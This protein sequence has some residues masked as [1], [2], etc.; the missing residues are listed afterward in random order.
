MDNIRKMLSIMLGKIPPK[1]IL[2][3]KLTYDD[4]SEES[5]VRLSTYYAN[6]YSNTELHNLYSCLRDEYERQTNWLEGKAYRQISHKMNVFHVV[7]VFAMHVLIEYD[8]I[9]VCRYENLLRWRMTSHELDEDIF[10]T[11]FLAYNDLHHFRKRE[12]FYWR[13]VIGHNNAYLNRIL[14]Q[15]MAEN[16]FH[17]KG[18]APQFP[19]SWINLMND[20]TNKEFFKK[21]K[22]YEKERLVSRYQTEYSDD[23]LVIYWWK[24]ALLRCF[25]YA[26]LTGKFLDIK[27][28]YVYP[29]EVIYKMSEALIRENGYEDKETLLRDLGHRRYNLKQ[30][31]M[32]FEQR[33]FYELY[34]Q[35]TERVVQRLLESSEDDIEFYLANLQRQIREFQIDDLFSRE[36]NASLDYALNALRKRGRESSVSGCNEILGGERWFLYTMFREIFSYSTTY[37]KYKNWFYAYLVIKIYIR[38]E[39]IQVNHNIGFDNFLNYQNRK[40]D[41]VEDTKMEDI[42]LQ[43]AVRDTVENQPIRFLE[44]RVSPRKTAKED[45]DYI[46]RLDNKINAKDRNKYFY[47]FHFVKEKDEKAEN[48]P[49]GD[50]QY[51]HYKFR[52]KIKSQAIAIAELRKNNYEVA[53]R[54]HGIDACSAEIPCRP[55]V[56]GQV[57][58]YLKNHEVFFE[59]QGEKEQYY[60]EMEENDNIEKLPRL[61]TTYHVGEDCEDIIDGLRAID[62]VIRFCNL[63]RGDR[64]GHGLVLG[65]DIVEWYRRRNY[66]VS[67]SKQ[68]YLDNIVW[69]YYQ[70]QKFGLVE[71]EDV[72]VLLE[73]TYEELFQ[74][75][76]GA[77]LNE[78][79]M[80][81]VIHNARQY[82]RE[83]VVSRKDEFVDAYRDG[84]YVY[85][86]GNYKFHISTYYNSWK[87]RGDDPECYENGFFMHKDFED[88]L[89]NYYAVNAEDTDEFDIRYNPE[90][91]YL[92][93]MYHYNKRARKIGEEDTEVRVSTRLVQCLE[94]VQQRLLEYIAQKGIGIETNPSSN[95]LI[96]SFK[97]YDSHPIIKFYN[98]SLENDQKKIA[99][100]PQALVSINTDDQGVFS[101]YLENEYALLALALEKKKDQN[102]NPMYN[103]SKIYQ[104]IDEIREMGIY[105]GFIGEMEPHYGE[106]NNKRQL[107]FPI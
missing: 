51:R 2:T 87:L 67:L 80:N 90:C 48:L 89:W 69:L 63:E 71:Y 25:L 103:R 22:K 27:D 53:R 82:F 106:L 64:I 86:R 97:R 91:T 44:A 49:D 46:T 68:N 101:T 77:N 58:R 21:L 37:E 41:F 19:L 72:A 60:L 28:H 92:Y 18:S 29:N 93:F 81:E 26:K 55:E 7:R 96:G 52:K 11:S 47:V 61:R 74:E 6:D 99:M 56:F 20:V 38:S 23:M 79:F 5:F 107:D 94:Q 30:L 9:P 105:Q 62:E 70:I 57:Y 15:G 12:Q 3:N 59:A 40:E 32:F 84:F 8:G 85:G 35:F 24:A 66:I 34:D 39:L 88:S 33:I 54:I 104:W 17:L 65:E 95:Y 13:P 1:A 83:Y 4:F 75:I 78:P 14:G 73:K 36:D 102:G 100:C 98:K 31:K 16:H 43:M 76:Y 10:T 42:Y 50:I 45:A